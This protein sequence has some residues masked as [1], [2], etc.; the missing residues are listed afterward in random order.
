MEYQTLISTSD[1]ARHVD[2]PDWLLLDCR[3]QLA[4]PAWGRQAYLDGHIPGALY[5]H[6]DSDLSGPVVPWMTGRHPLPPV[7][8]QQRVFSAWGIDEKVQ[9]VAYDDAGG[10]LA[11]VRAWWMLRALGHHRVAVL[12]GGFAAWIG[13]GRALRG[14][15]E[16]RPARVFTPQPRGGLAVDAAQVEAARQDPQWRVFDVR[17]PE[18]YRGD[19]EP[20]DRVAG[21]IPGALNLPYAAN[22]GTDGCFLTSQALRDYYQRQLGD[23]PAERTIFYCGSGVT[24]IHSILA[25]LHAGF[26]EAKLYP[27]S[28]SEW[29]ADP[30]R[31]VAYGS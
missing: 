21:H 13:A 26:G 1:L 8:F 9:V 4:D 22:L 18:R 28:W 31:P 30:S 10:A 11:A 12:D 16:L 23:I 20:I 3:F 5:A 25:M 27:G 2:D 6:L 14:G 7:D 29:I 19:L 24:S 17:Q 15:Q